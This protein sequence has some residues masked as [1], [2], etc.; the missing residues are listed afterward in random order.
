MGLG[1]AAGTAPPKLF[2][3]GGA[4]LRVVGMKVCFDPAKPHPA[5]AWRTQDTPLSPQQFTWGI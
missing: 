2:R 4:N 3:P 1:N 5:Y